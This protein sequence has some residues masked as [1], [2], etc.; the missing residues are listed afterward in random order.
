MLFVYEGVRLSFKPPAPVAAAVHGVNGEPVYVVADAGQVSAVTEA[1]LV[2]S[3]V[4]PP[5]LAS[6]LASPAKL[7]F[8]VAVP[9]FVLSV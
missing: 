4:A 8:T 1:A 9:A 7:A 3:N 6:W 5:L 2:I